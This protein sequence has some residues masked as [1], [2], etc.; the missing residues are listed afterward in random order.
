MFTTTYKKALA[1]VFL[2]SIFVAPLA[3]LEAK[4]TYVNA[5]GNT[6]STP[7]YAKVIPRGATARCKD[8]TYSFSQSRRGTCSG[9]KGVSS[10][11]K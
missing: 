7:V 10:W 9:H 5:K 8:G 1:S 2:L 11:L 4:G 3:S 6:V